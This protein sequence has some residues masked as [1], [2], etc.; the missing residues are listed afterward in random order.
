MAPG[1]GRDSKQAYR[2]RVGATWYWVD[3]TV[4]A[5]ELE[6]GDMVVIYPVNGLA[7]LAV[8]QDKF[9]PAQDAHFASLEGGR[10][11]LPASDIAAVHLAAV[12]AAP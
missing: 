3:P 6:G 8:L 5:E 12:D 4:P 7:H 11:S 2:V 1:D 10:F 9:D